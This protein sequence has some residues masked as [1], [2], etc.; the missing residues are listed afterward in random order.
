MLINCNKYTTVMR[1]VDSGGVY[2]YVGTDRIWEH[3]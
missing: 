1:D 2:A 3:S